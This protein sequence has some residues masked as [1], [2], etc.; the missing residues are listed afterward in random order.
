MQSIALISDIHANLP[1]LESVLKEIEDLGIPHILCCG[2]IIGYGPHPREC[3]EILRERN[4]PCVLGNH[5]FYALE[6]R[7]HKALREAEDEL[8]EDPVWA[9]IL[10]AV[11]E[12][13]EDDFE[14]LLGLPSF[15]KLPGVI[16]GHAALH[17][18]ENWPYLIDDEDVLATLEE[19]VSR[20]VSLGFF[21]HS[22]DQLWFTRSPEWNVMRCDTSQSVL[23][24]EQPSAVV[25]GSVGQ[26]RTGDPRAGWTL[27]Q[28]QAGSIEFRRT[29]YPVEKT[30][31]AILACGLPKQNA[32]R[33]SRG[34]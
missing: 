8:H 11:H 15:L 10:H 31:A 12:L 6:L 26:P 23:P 18:V 1:A 33:L 24:G 4:V 20:K 21:G 32:H 9:G 3:V 30:M 2:D 7:N 17:D 34:V 27:W 29:P 16:V 25:V 14:W 19:L 22:H 28:P 5:D 13:R